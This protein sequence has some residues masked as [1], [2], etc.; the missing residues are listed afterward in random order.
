MRKWWLGFCVG[1]FVAIPE[2]GLELLLSSSRENFWFLLFG[3]LVRGGLAG[4]LTTARASHCAPA[5]SAVS[6]S[7]SVSAF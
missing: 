6:S 3:A 5:F 7:M 1:P 2:F 4:L